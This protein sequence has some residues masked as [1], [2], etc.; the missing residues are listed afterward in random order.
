MPPNGQPTAA[1]A[2]DA[3]ESFLDFAEKNLWL[4]LVGGLLAFCA[5]VLVLVFVFVCLRR[6]G[7]MPRR[8][9]NTRCDKWCGLIESTSEARRRKSHTRRREQLSHL[10]S[11]DTVDTDELMPGR[12]RFSSNGR[13]RGDSWVRSSATI[14]SIDSR[15]GGERSRKSGREEGDVA[16]HTATHVP[17]GV[18]VVGSEAAAG[19]DNQVSPRLQTTASGNRS[20]RRHERIASSSSSPSNANTSTASA[21]ASQSISSQPLTVKVSVAVPTTT[22]TTT[23]T[24]TRGAVSPPKAQ[25]GIAGSA[26]AAHALLSRPDPITI[27]GALRPAAFNPRTAVNNTRT[28]T[29][30]ATTTSSNQQATP[31]RK[32]GPLPPPP[33]SGPHALVDPFVYELLT[34]A[35]LTAESDKGSSRSVADRSVSEFWASYADDRMEQ[36]DKLK[37]P[38]FAPLVEEDEGDTASVISS[39]RRSANGMEQR[40]QAALAEKEARKKQAQAGSSGDLSDDDEDE[41][42]DSSSKG[43]DKE[44]DDEDD[45]DDDDDVSSSGHG[46][47]ATRRSARHS[48]SSVIVTAAT[49]GDDGA[50]GPTSRFSRATEG[51]VSTTSTLSTQQDVGIFQED[52]IEDPPIRVLPDLNTDVN[53]NLF[54]RVQRGIETYAVMLT[55]SQ[56][57]ADDCDVVSQEQQARIAADFCLGRPPAAASATA[58]HQQLQHATQ[59]PEPL[60]GP[61]ATQAPKQRSRSQQADDKSVTKRTSRRGPQPPEP[62][63]GPLATQTPKHQSQQVDDKSATKRKSRR[64]LRLSR[65]RSKSREQKPRSSGSDELLSGSPSST[66]E[67]QHVQPP[68]FPELEPVFEVDRERERRRSALNEA[69]ESAT[70][71]TGHTRRTR[72]S[73]LVEVDLSV[74]DYYFRNS[75]NLRS[76]MRGD[77]GAER[78]P[79]RKR[80]RGHSVGRDRGGGGGGGGESGSS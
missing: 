18:V 35:M 64:G 43:D 2:T 61:L 59:P 75:D 46:S 66:V 11:V 73:S 13:A 78:V 3:L 62:L 28:R 29:P 48:V 7:C 12:H 57:P 76:S 1:P 79:Q 6:S 20:P 22:T 42:G 68:D 34:N 8:C 49:V 16:L 36:D 41:D 70:A 23:T 26:V 9:T 21:A 51:S 39:K 71:A 52:S 30:G 32:H 54:V 15:V 50:W 58:A 80:T 60:D 65:R 24:K 47:S 56:T 72:G 25:L 69:W 37:V 40:L 44:D 5:L 33:M 31:M 55:P 14:N 10:K 38:W 74:F 27:A 17:S 4:T 63:D 67:L 19:D 77:E 53:G 45:D